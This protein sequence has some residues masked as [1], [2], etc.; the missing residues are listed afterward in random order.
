MTRLH[1]RSKVDKDFM[2]CLM[3]GECTR[4]EGVKTGENVLPNGNFSKTFKIVNFNALPFTIIGYSISPNL[5]S[6]SSAK[7][8]ILQG[9][10]A[11]HQVD[12]MQSHGRLSSRA[13]VIDARFRCRIADYGMHSVRRR[14]ADARSLLWTA[15]ELLGGGDDATPVPGG[16]K[17]GDIWSIAVVFV[18]IYTRRPPY[19][20]SL[21]VDADDVIR[22]VSAGRLRPALPDET[23]KN[24]RSTAPAKEKV[25]AKTVMNGWTSPSTES[26]ATIS[27]VSID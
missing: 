25:V 24:Q 26:P 13:I 3:L 8:D 17:P 19:E 2:Y 12:A 20:E 10:C 21:S 22:G 4:E 6:C 7:S 18:E 11:I 16:T 14:R 1:S 27:V 9:I 15:P 23:R 5:N